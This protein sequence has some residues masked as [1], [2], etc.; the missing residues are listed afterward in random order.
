MS[1]RVM[2]GSSH[3]GLLFVIAR[4]EMSGTSSG[5]RPRVL[6]GQ[7]AMGMPYGSVA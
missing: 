2:A 6:E 4:E 1:N 3:Y 7:Q 5:G